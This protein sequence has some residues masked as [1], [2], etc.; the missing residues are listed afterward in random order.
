M[1]QKGEVS[2]QEME[3]MVESVVISRWILTG[4]IDD[5]RL[6]YHRKLCQICL[7]YR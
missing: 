1:K 5:I 4:L 3:E 6:P 7:H 2:E